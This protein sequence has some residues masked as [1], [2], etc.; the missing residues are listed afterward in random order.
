[1]LSLDVPTHLKFF[2]LLVDP[3]AVLGLRAFGLQGSEEFATPAAKTSKI[4]SIA[5]KSTF[6]IH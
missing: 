4:R 3:G 6:E 1:M 5:L 2:L